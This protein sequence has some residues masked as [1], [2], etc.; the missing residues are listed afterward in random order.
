[1]RGCQRNGVS[2]EIETLYRRST[3]TTPVRLPEE[4]RLV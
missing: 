3:A 4:W 2:F 1:L